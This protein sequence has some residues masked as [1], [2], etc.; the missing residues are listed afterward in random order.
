MSFSDSIFSPATLTS[1]RVTPAPV[2][3]ICDICIDGCEGPCEIGRSA[4][5]NLP[6]ENKMMHTFRAIVIS[7][8]AMIAVLTIVGATPA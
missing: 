8:A 2:S 6:E 3:D 5:N 1:T 4:I 7:L